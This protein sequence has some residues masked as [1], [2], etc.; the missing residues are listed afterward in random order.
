VLISLSRRDRNVT[1]ISWSSYHVKRMF[2]IRYYF[3][4]FVPRSFITPYSHLRFR[5]RNVRGFLS[6]HLDL[7]NPGDNA[8]RLLPRFTSHYVSF[9]TVVPSGPTTLCWSSSVGYDCL[10]KSSKTFRESNASFLYS[11]KLL[12]L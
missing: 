4:V 6:S 11:W 8:W 10:C 7:S 5:C 2:I 12:P 9:L 3:P 1:M